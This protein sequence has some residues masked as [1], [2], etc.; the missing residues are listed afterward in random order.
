LSEKPKYETKSIGFTIATIVVLSILYF[1]FFEETKLVIRTILES[2]VTYALLWITIVVIFLFN[3]FRTTSK[4]ITREIILTEKFGEFTDKA[5]G[6]ISYGTVVTTSLTLLKGIYIQYFF[7]DKIYFAEFQ[8]IDLVT[9]FA[10]SLFLLYSSVTKVVDIAKDTYR[11]GQTE[12]VKKA[13]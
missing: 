10:I 12:I 2:Q 8:N 7:S 4:N 6:G 13:D 5:L 11:V 9:I 1:Y 3:Y